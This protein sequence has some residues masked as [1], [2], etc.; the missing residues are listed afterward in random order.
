MPA[1]A[2]TGTY[3]LPGMPDATVTAGWPFAGLKL[4]EIFRNGPRPVVCDIETYGVG[5][6]AGPGR[7]KCVILATDREAVVLN[8]REEGDHAQIRRALAYAST[9]VEHKANFDSPSLAINRLIDPQGVDK[10]VDT[11]VLARMADPG[12]T[13]PKTLDAL[14]QRYLKITPGKIEHLFKSLGFK[15]KAEGFL[16][17]DIDSPAYLMGA[18]SDGIATYRIW[19]HV[20]RAALARFADHPFGAGIGL[21]PD[22]AA[23][24]IEKTQVVNRNR[25]KQT[26][27]GLRVD[28]EFLDRYR[29]ETGRERA[30]GEATLREAGITPGNGNHLTAWLEEAG[31][32]PPDHRRT[33]TGKLGAAAKDLETIHHPLAAVFRAVKESEK[34]DGYLQ[35]CVDMM[36]EQGRIHPVT[37]VLK[38]AHGRDSMADPPLHQFPGPSRGIILADTSFTSVDWSQQEPRILMN[39]AGDVGPLFDYEQFGTKVYKGIADYADVSD[40]QAKIVVLAGAYGQGQALLSSQLGL[41]PDPWVPEWTTSWGKVIEA[42]WG[43][44]GAKDVQAAVF[45]AI[46]ESKKFMDRGKQI[47][48]DHKLAYTVAG[49]ILPV[50]SGYFKGKFSVQAHKWINYVVSGSAADELHTA[51]YTAITTGLGDAIRWNMHDEMICE[52]EAAHDLRRIM[53]TPS[54]RFCRLAGRKPVIRTDFDVLGERWRTA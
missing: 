19:P 49:R 8:P 37:D 41:P 20:Y 43:Y 40:K 16:R 23:F 6:D 44:Q 33:D 53:E 50:P 12:E 30:A 3:P 1:P 22:E 21:S 32:L 31:A 42:H 46:P 17:L 27:R 29:A 25:I 4:A 51:E 14:V 10:V 28:V 26:I 34:L 45:S 38:A 2:L 36:D 52:S 47:A 15:N 39:L 9:V 54:E 7:I 24:E 35:K 11:L 5:A 13:V 48:R 18:A